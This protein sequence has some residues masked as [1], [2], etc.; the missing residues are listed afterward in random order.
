MQTEWLDRTEYPFDGEYFETGAGEMHYL[1]EGDDDAPPVLMLHGNPTWSFMYRDFVKELREDY[2]CVVPD[3]LGF[4]L[5]EKPEGWTYLPEDHS[6]NVEALIE[7]L[8]LEDVTLVMHDYG[9]PIG[10]RYAVDNPGNV[11]AVAPMNTFAWRVDDAVRARIFSATVGGDVGRALIDETNLFA[12]GIMRLGFG[13]RRWLPAGRDQLPRDLHRQYT[14][15]LSKPSERTGTW[16]FPGE[17]TGSSDWFE[18]IWNR[19]D[20]LSDTPG[21]VAWGTKDPAFGT[22]DSRRWLN[23]LGETR[24]LRYDAGHYLPEARGD[25][26]APRLKAFLDTKIRG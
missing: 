13:D 17:L 20:V 12:R 14:I 5:S 4:G 11:A 23:T 15:P 25:E 1:D 7:Y 2:R 10:T 16:T 3:Y 8:G 24:Y 9:G 22:E 19:R 21:F 26:I 18:Q 6:E